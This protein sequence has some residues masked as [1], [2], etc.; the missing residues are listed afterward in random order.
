MIGRGITA[1]LRGRR[2]EFPRPV[3]SP[4]REVSVGTGGV[5]GVDSAGDG[6]RSHLGGQ[7]DGHGYGADSRVPIA[8]APLAPGVEV[9]NRADGVAGVAASGEGGERHPRRQETST[10]DEMHV[11]VSIGEAMQ[12]H[13]LD[14]RWRVRT[15]SPCTPT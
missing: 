6:R 15:L 8:Q 14:P 11:L 2:A 4:I 7:K 10:G 3:G 13:T 5:T 1:S 9:S 12:S